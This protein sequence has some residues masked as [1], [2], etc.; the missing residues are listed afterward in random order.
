MSI[1]KEE[2]THC[3]VINCDC[4][5]AMCKGEGVEGEVANHIEVCSCGECH[6]H[7]SKI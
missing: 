4:D 3:T 1:T 7:F 6:R 2:D 5:D